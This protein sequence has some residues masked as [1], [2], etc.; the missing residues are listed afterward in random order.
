MKARSAQL[1]A[2][3]NASHTSLLDLRPKAI[4]SLQGITDRVV[5]GSGAP[6]ARRMR[7]DGGPSVVQQRGT[8]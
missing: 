3:L 1:G 8:P 2:I 7:S 5:T 4:T 6:T